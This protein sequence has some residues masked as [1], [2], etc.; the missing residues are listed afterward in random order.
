M[1]VYG[2]S[3]LIATVRVLMIFCIFSYNRGRHLLNCVSSIEQCIE[4]PD[5]R[6]FDDNSDD[7]ETLAALAVI[8]QKH[9]V[10]TP[11]N[12]A[13]QSKHGGLYGN[14][15]RALDSLPGEAYACFLQDD[16][17]LVRPLSK[18]ELGAIYQ[19]F[20]DFESMAFM[21]PTF[22][23]LSKKEKS[24]KKILPIDNTFYFTR[25][26]INQSAGTC[27]S[28]IFIAHVGRLQKKRWTF[29]NREKLNEIQ[30]QNYFEPM[31]CLL[32]PFIMWLPN[33]SCYRG[34]KKS[35][36]LKIAEKQCK[37]GLY[38]AKIMTKEESEAFI[39]RDDKM[40]P[41]A[42]DHISIVGVNLKK[43]WSLH[44][45]EGRRVLKSLEKIELAIAKIL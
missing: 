11:E 12:D 27:Y 26:I 34:K 17:Q 40:L 6:V 15:Q 24:L 39:H 42:E 31:H 22:L 30:A 43:P 35:L 13:G 29:E 38:P 18:D 9:T 1:L 19:H 5:I 2:A 8:A 44:P 14:M 41:F 37:A 4:A 45:L 32:S 7:P 23:K 25:K 36:A 3:Y 16:M 33:V 28:D 10:T 20:E 21:S